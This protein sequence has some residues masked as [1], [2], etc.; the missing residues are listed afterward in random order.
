MRHWL[1][2]K[3][4]KS[5]LKNSGYLAASK[6]VAAVAALAALAFSGRA[7]GV[8]LLGMLILIHSYSKAASGI[9]K[10]QSWQ[11]IIRYGG[12]VISAGQ[13]DEFKT[14]TGFA[15]ALDVV[16]GLAGMALALLLLPLIGGWFGI[17][18][19]YLVAAMVYC[20]LIPSTGAA[21]PVGVLRALDR[22][23]LISWQ[24]TSYPIARAILCFVAW[25]NG[26]GFQAFLAIWF[27]TE[28][29]GQLLMWWLAWR[30]LGNRGLLRGIRPTL[31][32][33]SLPGAWRFAIHVNLTSSLTTAWGPIARLLIGGLIGPAGAAVYRIAASL[34]DAAQRPADML[35]KAY[36]PEV[37]RMDLAT[38]RPWKLMLRGTALATVMGVVA[39]A[40]LAI[41]GRWLI[42]A[43][44]GA[45]F[46]PAYPVLL[47]L[48]LAP[49]LG[50]IS[51]PLPP[52]LYALDRPDAP[53]KARLA[54]TI[55]YFLIVA[56]LCWRLG[57][58]GA[59][60]AFV[61][62]DAAMVA[63]LMIQVRGEYRRVRS[64]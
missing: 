64:A 8:E 48:I 29:F 20:L 57:V 18:E 63:I 16:S 35:A 21:T 55:L 3:H 40:V 47:V 17:S 45:E 27:A 13:V 4:F 42:D 12:Q 61:I 51:F 58:T 23:D 2:D 37:V 26:A 25:V 36:Y 56:P 9:S 39:V 31:R 41:G 52:M 1:R 28:I 53:L 62:A 19:D 15:F 11:L 38:K 22:F 44:F 7:L 46:L 34:A 54:G 14:S 49:L 10:F 60:I 33:H 50:M 59:A 6:S 43:I 5:L 30:E 24:G 32:P